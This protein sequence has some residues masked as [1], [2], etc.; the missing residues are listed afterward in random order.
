MQH[1]SIAIRLS[2][3]TN[4]AAGWFQSHGENAGFS[5]NQIKELH[6]KAQVALLVTHDDGALQA[7]V[8]GKSLS[9]FF[10]NLPKIKPLPSKSQSMVAQ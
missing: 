3:A 10:E 5:T 4:K 8:Q 1:D 7:L 2:T 9:P 6:G